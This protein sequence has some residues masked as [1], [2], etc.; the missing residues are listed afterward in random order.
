[1]GGIFIS[2][3]REDSAGWTGRLAER[4]KQKFGAASIFMDIDRIEPGTDFA[5]ALR[6]AVGGCE[7]LL[8]MIG[9]EW[10]QTKNAE[11]QTRVHDPNDWVRAE[12]TAA[13]N[14]NIPVIPVLVGGASLPKLATLPDDL[15]KLVQYQAHELTDKRWEY[16]AN[17]LVQVLEKVVRGEKP[18]RDLVQ[19]I[20]LAGRSMGMAAAILGL[21]LVFFAAIPFVKGRIH[22]DH[23]GSQT[24]ESEAPQ[25][26][27]VTPQSEPTAAETSAP[28]VTHPADLPTENTAN[29]QQ[30][31]DAK[32]ETVSG[33]AMLSAVI[34]NSDPEK[35]TSAA[36]P[37]DQKGR[38]LPAGI[39]VKLGG[40]DF[41]CSVVSIRLEDQS[42][43]KWLLHTSVVVRNIDA[44]DFNFYFNDAIRLLIDDNIHVPT[45]SPFGGYFT[46]D[47]Q[48]GGNLIFIVPKTARRAGLRIRYGREHTIIPIDLKTGVSRSD[49]QPPGIPKSLPKPSRMNNVFNGAVN[50]D[51]R[52]VT[53]EPYNVET[54][55]LRLSVRATTND[56]DFNFHYDNF[57]LVFDDLP[58]VPEKGPSQFLHAQTGADADI[59]FA[60]PKS[61]TQVWLRVKDE[62]KWQNVPIDLMAG[63]G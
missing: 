38:S 47:S 15:Q 62:D 46:R 58:H 4:L 5:E 40:G 42:Q 44:P 35:L 6:A 3:R 8:A 22:T 45:D 41:M 26:S 31:T 16:D 49:I 24:I 23:P 17:Q 32:Q 51:F 55:L 18:K 50:Y 27:L 52:A 11:G 21:V 19:S 28:A 63:K 48:K 56:R 2:Y 1:M 43:D 36:S 12:V 29:N 61:V 20:L 39:E 59:L 60:V 9:P 14:R 34:E 30:S 54:F 37:T 57:R 10:S 25:S 7:V 13:L 33:V 53:L